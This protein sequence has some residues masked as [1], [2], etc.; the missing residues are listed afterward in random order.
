MIDQHRSHV[1]LAEERLQVGCVPVESSDEIF[2]VDGNCDSLRE[3]LYRLL[4]LVKKKMYRFLEEL[5]LTLLHFAKHLV[6]RILLCT[7]N[8][9]QEYPEVLSQPQRTL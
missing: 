4:V 1:Y 9:L 6:R 8:R 2:A 7:L 5:G 3:P